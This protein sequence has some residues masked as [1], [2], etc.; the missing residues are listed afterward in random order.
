VNNHK[1][2]L[3][4]VAICL[5][6]AACGSGGDSHN[7]ISPFAGNWSGSWADTLGRQ[8]GTLFL[9]IANS[10]DATGSIYNTTLGLSGTT[11]GNITETGNGNFTY[12]YP[13]ETHTAAC[14][15]GFNSEGHLVGSCNE[16][17]G[18]ILI[19]VSNIDLI[20]N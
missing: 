9:S 15:V 10:G 2:F 19:G 12:A 18:A 1:S 16:Y 3:L 17:S 4:L 13:S 8:S 5:I 20:K 7:N 6:I 14:T 11:F